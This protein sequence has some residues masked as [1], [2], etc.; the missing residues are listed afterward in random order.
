[1]KLL[2]CMAA[3]ALALTTCTSSITQAQTASV[4]GIASEATC[5]DKPGTVGCAEGIWTLNR[6]GFAV[7][8]V[9]DKPATYRICVNARARGP[10]LVAVD[11]DVI[12]P[13]G[14][15]PAIYPS[16]VIEQVFNSACALVTGKFIHVQAVDI[17]SNT[18]PSFGRYQRMDAVNP[19]NS[20][21]PYHLQMVA[22]AGKDN[23]A[24]L[25][26]VQETRLH[27][28]C[29]GPITVGTETTG[30]RRHIYTDKGFVLASS[31]ALR[32]F[33]FSNSTCVDLDAKQVVMFGPVPAS[34]ESVSGFVAY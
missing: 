22:E 17:L 30:E 16:P 29:I 8:A 19:L 11:L 21:Y 26:A 10:V 7:I 6:S 28:V 9:L 13:Q 27:R 23:S 4:V 34:N 14:H 24:L 18:L 1:M 31:N 12:T 32:G 5:A 2:L 25:S 33:P 20:L 3:L 15:R